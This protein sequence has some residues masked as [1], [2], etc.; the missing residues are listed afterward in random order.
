MTFD[1]YNYILYGLM[2]VEIVV[3]IIW[4]ILTIKE[5]LKK[6]PKGERWRRKDEI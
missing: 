5:I 6:K 3:L 1:P 4:I 2:C